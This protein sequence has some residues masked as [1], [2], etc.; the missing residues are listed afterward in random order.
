M[1]TTTIAMLAAT[2]AVVG[3]CTARPPSLAEAAVHECA[4]ATQRCDGELTVPLNW[5][6]P[7]SERITVSFAWIPRRD[8]SRP[9]TGTVLTL[10]GGPTAALPM[11][12]VYQR[13]LGPVLDRQNML[14]IDP[15]GFGESTPLLC[16]DIEL[17]RPETIAGCARDL[18]P[19]AR[20]FTSDQ[21]VH[22]FDAVRDALGVRGVSVYGSSYGTVWAQAYAA[23]F[24]ERTRAVLVDSVVRVGRDGYTD[25]APGRPVRP[26]LANLETV[27]AASRSCR[28][29]PGTPTRTWSELVARLRNR[30]DPAVSRLAL[31]RLPQ[32][33]TEPAVGREIVAAA[34]A[35]LDADPLPLRR[36]VRTFVPSSAPPAR[37]DPTVAGYLAYMCGDA[38]Y[39]Y[40][41]EAAPETRRRQLEA[42]YA[43]LRPFDPFTTAEVLGATGGDQHQWCLNWP[44]PRPSP[45]VPPRAR[46]G[47][48]PML[49]VGGELDPATPAGNAVE[50]AERFP[51]GRAVVHRFGGHTAA[52]GALAGLQGPHWTCALDVVR[53]FLAA[54]NGFRPRDGCSA[55]SYRAVGAF[56]RTAGDIRIHTVPRLDDGEHAA[57]AAA[58]AAAVDGVARRDPNGAATS[59]LTGEPGL[60]GGMLRFPDAVTV[61]LDHVRHV[62]DVEVTGRVSLG[63]RAYA[64]LT[65]SGG[66]QV[67]LSW[68]PFQPD[69]HIRVGGVLD[70]HRR[71]AAWMSG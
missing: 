54:P 16:P 29:L 46:Y 62:R 47:T 8:R 11:T 34:H 44:T 12:E 17:D 10:H 6:E 19:R 67:T 45:P 5:A 30:P 26:D 66:R 35:Y 9:A 60:R 53:K 69:D 52:L 55:E 51:R 40:E 61:E 64:S 50:L 37:P 25:W 48:V 20:F 2:A 22:D 38:S 14:V 43:R 56:P 70:G 15:R 13:A 71:F 21:A 39:A 4:A 31:L 32:Q 41:R 68:R 24:P 28:A 59:R 3:L 33:A 27:C 7:G 58:L 57:V 42:A 36:L 23:R 63:D 1:G 18:G 65:V 49:A